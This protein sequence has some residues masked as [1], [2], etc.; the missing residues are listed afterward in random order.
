[1]PDA[2]PL[3]LQIITVRKA[4]DIGIAGCCNNIAYLGIAP[5]NVKTPG[6]FVDFIIKK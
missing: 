4:Q 6:I 1:M 2:Q 5:E 3:Q